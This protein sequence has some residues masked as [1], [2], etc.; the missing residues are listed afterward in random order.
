MCSVRNRAARSSQSEP[1]AYVALGSNLGDRLLNFSEARRRLKSLGRLESGPV[2]E[3]EALLPDHDAVPQPRYLNSVDALFT[4]LSPDELFVQLKRFEREMGRTSSSRWAPRI[5]DLDL[6]L[7]GS[8]VI[9]TEKLTV[10]HPQMHLRQFVL[11]PLVALAPDVVHP[12]LR[13]TA[14]QLLSQLS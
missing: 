11:K 10:P 1:V 13:R 9:Q 14:L 5:I 2:L 12:I 7:F 3:T 8:E 6:I 4:L